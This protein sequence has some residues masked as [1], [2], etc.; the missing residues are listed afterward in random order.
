MFERP[1]LVRTFQLVERRL[2]WIGAT[3]PPG[4]MPSPKAAVKADG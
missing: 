3:P 2:A 4:T 1:A